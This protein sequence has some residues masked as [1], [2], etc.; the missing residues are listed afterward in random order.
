MMHEVRQLDHLF[1]V[2]WEHA[3][4]ADDDETILEAAIP[5]GAR[6]TGPDLAMLQRWRREHD[7]VWVSELLRCDGLAPLASTTTAKAGASDALRVLID[8]ATA[9]PTRVRA[10]RVGSP[11]LAAWNGVRVGHWLFA[12]GRVGQVTEVEEAG[13]V[14]L[15]APLFEDGERVV[16][17]RKTRGLLTTTDLVRLCHTALPKRLDMVVRER[18]GVVSIEHDELG[19]AQELERRLRRRWGRADGELAAEAAYHGNIQVVNA[20]ND[21][22]W[23]YERNLLRRNN[24][25]LALMCWNLMA[26]RE[27]GGLR[28]IE[29]KH[30][31]RPRRET[32]K[33]HPVRHSRDLQWQ[34][35]QCNS[36]GP[37]QRHDLRLV[38]P[39][40]TDRTGVWCEP[41]ETEIVGAGTAYEVT[42][43]AYRHITLT[44]QRRTANEHAIEKDGLFLTTFSRGALGRSAKE[45]TTK[46]MHDHLPT[47]ARMAIWGGDKGGPV[48]CA[49]GA[50][51]E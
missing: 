49:C 51:P 45:G 20:C 23:A 48:T 22:Q 41:L 25:D 3:P 35:G 26:A 32:Q 4:Y 14:V 12:M 2:G 39:L 44:S 8:R 50:T 30:P 21:G 27:R 29:A 31:K 16:R 42:S 17:K 13:V 34:S 10:P 7:L 11:T 18:E 38:G 19:A 43:G 1:C 6:L 33:T 15:A 9:G 46:M 36:H 40:S 47:A 5:D 24:R 28:R 37:R